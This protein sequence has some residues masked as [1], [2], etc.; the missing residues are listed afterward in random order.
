MTTENPAPQGQKQTLIHKLREQLN[1][2]SAKLKVK[3]NDALRDEITKLDTR[4]TVFEMWPK[5]ATD[6]ALKDAMSDLESLM[7]EV[8][9]LTK[10]VSEHDAL[11]AETRKNVEL[12]MKQP[13]ASK[14]ARATS[15]RF[16]KI[17]AALNEYA[18]KRT[19]VA[20]GS[21]TAEILDKKMA[22]LRTE[23]NDVSQF[24]LDEIEKIQAEVVEV[25]TRVDDH[26]AHITMLIGGQSSLSQRV[27]DVEAQKSGVNPLG[28]ILIGLLA[29]I[30]GWGA[31]LGHT[32]TSAPAANNPW[33]A[34]LAGAAVGGLS[35][36][37]CYA[38]WPAKKPATA[39][40]QTQTTDTVVAE[41]EKEGAHAQS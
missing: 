15:A 30:V 13:S 32:F 4:V 21:V 36:A 34:V 40:P 23:L 33:A 16:A 7:N 18:Q 6:E 1:S 41:Q 8:E 17:E 9:M 22:D 10:K 2:L 12:L 37:L 31:W 14:G 35:F 5:M 20:D 28:P 11:L 27:D 24:L 38:L 19:D 26:D 3:P 25:T 29:G 39:K